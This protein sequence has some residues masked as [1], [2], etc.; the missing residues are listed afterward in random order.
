MLAL[1]LSLLSKPVGPFSSNARLGI[2]FSPQHRKGESRHALSSFG[3][4]KYD[5][6]P[7]IRSLPARFKEK[8]HDL[9]LRRK[10]KPNKKAMIVK[11]IMKG[12]R[13]FP[14]NMQNSLARIRTKPDLQRYDIY[15]YFCKSDR[16]SSIPTVSPEVLPF[17]SFAV[18][19]LPHNTE[20][21]HGQASFST[22]L[23]CPVC[24]SQRKRP[25][26]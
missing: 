24:R 11:V 17:S 21:S 5:K 12:F 19:S 25:E 22:L 13:L 4:Q 2:P 23:A 10:K 9:R 18:S 6:I 15:A 7:K 8:L 1:P 3:L 14:Q 20:G 26:N 16:R